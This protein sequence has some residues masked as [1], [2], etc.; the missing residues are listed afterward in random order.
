VRFLVD[1]PVTPRAVTHLDAA[2]HDAVH[3][4][5]IGLA[6]ATDE[7]ILE[8]ARLE[9][10]TVITAELDYPRLLALGQAKGPGVVL[11][12]GGSYSDDEMLRLLDRVLALGRELDQSITVVDRSRIRRR[13]LPISWPRSEK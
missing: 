7:R 9:S 10:R 13:R 5:A 12:R 8:V 4:S 2:G 11:F 1:M 6:G 3:A